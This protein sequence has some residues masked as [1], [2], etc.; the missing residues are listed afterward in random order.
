MPAGRRSDGARSDSAG[1]PPPAEPPPPP[2]P[3]P[4]AHPPP[5]PRVV[6]TGT[7]F[8]GA[9][10]AAIRD[11]AAAIPGC[12]YSGDLMHGRTTHLVLAPGAAAGAA[13][14]KAQ[15][16]ARWG[17]PLV[18]LAWLLDSAAAGALQPV[19][20]YLAD[21]ES[22]AAA[23]GEAAAWQA[24]LRRGGAAPADEWQ[25]AQ[26][27]RPQQQP[28]H[29]SSVNSNVPGATAVA[30]APQRLADQPA[31]AAQPQPHVAAVTE[32]SGGGG[33]QELPPPEQRPALSPLHANA[34]AA[35][36]HRMSLSP[37]PQHTA[38]AAQQQEQQE[39]QQQQQQ[40]QE[41]QQC[42]GS[43]QGSLSLQ[44]LAAG[45]RPDSPPEV[46][47]GS[48][49]NGS[50]RRAPGVAGWSP[51][52]QSP[53][54]DGTQA[55]P[56]VAMAQ[57]SPVAPASAGGFAPAGQS[58]APPPFA[59]SLAAALGHSAS[60]ESMGLGSPM[61]A[62]PAPA[63]A[64]GLPAASPAAAAAS[65]PAA[66]ASPGVDPASPSL[67]GTD[68]A[69]PLCTLPTPACIRDWSD[70]GST[71]GASPA[72]RRQLA[73]AAA[74][75]AVCAGARLQPGSAAHCLPSVSALSCRRC[76]HHANAPG[77][78]AG[79]GGGCSPHA[80][81]SPAAAAAAGCSSGAAAGASSCSGARMER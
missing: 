2:P 76:R 31:D 75:V 36:L 41:R 51:M 80:V 47:G 68:G 29:R 14:R 65:S 61:L 44:G 8:W 81:A 63:A 19:Q 55:S 28:R 33:R 12:A 71:P 38:A 42:S 66:A 46:A 26:H 21:V 78:A 13:S 79:A 24:W 54:A 10:R 25:E 73:G 5:P 74:G 18:R 45:G 16:A 69:D 9:G 22:E 34:L 77:G 58:D 17:L 7:G 35:Q 67:S 37:E 70:D 56:D 57:P 60:D 52:Q 53:A 1:R 15:A 50:G 11:L 23:A 40:Q 27:P 30:R 3:P 62:S 59:F 39:Q 6:L 72:Q 4:A 43:P 32:C 48:G 49:G 20:C 64:A